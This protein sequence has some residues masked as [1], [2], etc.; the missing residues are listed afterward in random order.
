[1]RV[2]KW[3]LTAGMLATGAAVP[4]VSQ[5]LPLSMKQAVEIAL[6]PEGS[7][8]IQL[9]REAIRQAQARAGQVRAALLPNVESSVGEQ[10]ITR[11]LA[12]FGI[13]ME[14]PIPGFT[15][16]EKVGPFNV[17]DARAT[18]T[19]NL[20]NLSAIRRYQAAKAGV[21]AAR[22]AN[23]STRDQVA[24]QVARA[25][26]AALRAEARVEASKANIGLARALLELAQNQKAA[27]TAT[28]IDVTRANVQLS[29]EKQLL[30]VAENNR[31]RAHL[32]L[33]RAMDLKLETKLDLSDKLTYHPVEPFTEQE[34]LR[35][36]IEARADWKAQHRREE[37][38]RMGY[39]A[40]KW[41][42][43]PSVS[44]FGDYGAI[45]NGLGDAFS[46]RT[47]GVRLRVPVFDGGRMDAQRAE[48]GSMLRQEKIL[49]ADLRT[50][51]ELETRLALDSLHSSAD[52]VTVAGEGLKLAEKELAQAQRRF[53]AGVT[54]SV[55]VTDAQN[56]L[57][58]A[59]DNRIAALF[60]Y[61]SARLDLG[62]AIGKI[63]DWVVGSK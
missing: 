19:Q 6:E 61:E 44:A 31:R 22:E 45:G 48:A 5:A 8:R 49:T 15:F 17:F 43:L 25:Y 39:S 9:A 63:R 7:V 33:L 34:A 10:S 14:A 46:T 23:D 1:M 54:N 58:R 27:G 4:A 57:A 35:T 30:L 28:G 60:N 3:I 24:S 38:A 29:N 26:L 21:R 53:H 55:E 13:W 41:E 47:Y 20:F 16:P 2:F 62:Q 36:A 40:T 37:K 32:E 50:R 12:A 59:R 51:M 56:R 42:R 18:A 52:Q 11:N